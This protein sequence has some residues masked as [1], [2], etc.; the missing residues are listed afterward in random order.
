MYWL[1]ETASTDTSEAWVNAYQDIIDN[2][3]EWHD[4]T[5]TYL[6]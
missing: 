2:G 6:Q 4:A 5:T 1:N 3:Q